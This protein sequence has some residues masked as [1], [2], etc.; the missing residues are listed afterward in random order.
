MDANKEFG[1]AYFG[2]LS[3]VA[4]SI[5][6]ALVRLAKPDPSEVWHRLGQSDKR[7]AKGDAKF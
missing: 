7:T 6:V 4:L 1:F 3:A 2:S 5:A